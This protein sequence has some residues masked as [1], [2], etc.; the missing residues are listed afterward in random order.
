[1]IYNIVQGVAAAAFVVAAGLWLWASLIEVP[2]NIDTIV[3][4]LRR[5]SRVNAC[6]AI[7]TTVG[8]VCTALTVGAQLPLTSVSMSAA[9]IVGMLSAIFGAGG[10]LVLFFGS[11]SYEG[12]G[13]YENKQSIDAKIKRNERRQ[14][15]Q[16]VGLGLLM[17]SFLLA[18]VSVLLG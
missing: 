14:C 1:V 7:A 2:D 16:R 17:L 10:T 18:G 15:L 8:A 3:R 13:Q 9:K 12:F 6:A 4:E 5:I 11:F